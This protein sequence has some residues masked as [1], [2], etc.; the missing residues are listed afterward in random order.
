M[1]DCDFCE[2]GWLLESDHGCDCPCCS[3]ES[4]CGVCA[5]NH[6]CVICLTVVHED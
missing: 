5:S 3:H 1:S 2:S 4:Y 6:I